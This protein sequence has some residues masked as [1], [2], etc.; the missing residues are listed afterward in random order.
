MILL[1]HA[2]IVCFRSW[3]SARL[4]VATKRT[5]SGPWVSHLTYWLRML[6]WVKTIVRNA[7][8][9]FR[10]HT[11]GSLGVCLDLSDQNLIIE[12]RNRIHLKNGS[13]ISYA[14]GFRQSKR[15]CSTGFFWF[16]QNLIVE[17]RNRIHLKNGSSISY[18]VG[19]RQSKRPCSSTGFFW[20]FLSSVKSFL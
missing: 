11:K 20:F 13:S 3:L 5:R 15:P 1:Y 10:R 8:D 16:F 2:L 19:F 7:L 4:P 17:A 12:A 18:T 14:V 9:T 6:D